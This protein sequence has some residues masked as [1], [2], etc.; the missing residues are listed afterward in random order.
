MLGV[1][2]FTFFCVVVLASDTISASFIHSTTLL[3]YTFIFCTGM[4]DGVL[5]LLILC[6]ASASVCLDLDWGLP[7]MKNAHNTTQLL[8]LSPS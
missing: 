7:N 5:S 4:E 2:M 6:D 1:R 8:I 3:F